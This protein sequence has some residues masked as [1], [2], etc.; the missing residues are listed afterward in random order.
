MAERKVPEIPTTYLSKSGLQVS[1]ICFGLMSLGPGDNRLGSDFWAWTQD[2]ETVKPLIQR[3]LESGINFFDTAN[4]YSAGLSETYFG[5]IIK[6]LNLHREDLVIA[7]KFSFD[8][9]G[10]K[11]PNRTGRSRKNILSSCEESLKRL[12]TDYIDLYIVHN[13]SND[14]H[15]SVE[16]T[17]EALNDLVRSGKVRYIGTSNMSGWL[18]TKAN[19]IAE[20]K[21]WAKFIC[22]QNLYNPIYREDER[23]VIRA[24][25]DQGIGYTPWSP[26][27]GGFLAG[28]RKQGVKG[29]TQRAKTIGQIMNNLDPKE[30]DWPT[31]DRVVQLAAN[32]NVP[33]TQLVLAWHLSKPFVTAPIIGVTKPGHLEDAIAAIKIKLTNEDIEFIESTYHA[34]FKHPLFD[35]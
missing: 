20:R 34:K 14:K 1:K 17:M 32:K 35:Y 21:G 24:C 6:E 25:I 15:T 29:D 19:E 30:N 27:H 26:L 4:N 33:P 5:Q 11:G 8:V 31:I 28:N 16:E 13:W 22:V 23:E 7:T 2:K 12:G 10:A 18:L 9:G 3:A